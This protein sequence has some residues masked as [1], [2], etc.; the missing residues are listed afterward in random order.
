MGKGEYSNCQTNIKMMIKIEI[1]EEV[2]SKSDLVELLN[3]IATKLESGYTSGYHPHWDLS[4]DYVEECDGCGGTGVVD[5]E[6]CVLCAG[7][8]SITKTV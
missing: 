1:S 4:G 5:G 2:S 3:E 7:N 8:G 6:D